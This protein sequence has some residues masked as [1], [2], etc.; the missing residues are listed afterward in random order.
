[1]GGSH[2]ARRVEDDVVGSGVDENTL[3][4]CRKFSKNK[5]VHNLKHHKRKNEMEHTTEEIS[6]FGGCFTLKEAT[7]VKLKLIF[8]EPQVSRWLYILTTATWGHSILLSFLST[9][10]FQMF[11]LLT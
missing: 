9:F 8:V 2:V 4:T 5:Q 10:A 1:M 11:L 3:Y 7:H 6:S